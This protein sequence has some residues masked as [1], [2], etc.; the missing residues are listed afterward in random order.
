M[1][2]NKPLPENQSADAEAV[3]EPLQQA[4]VD[5]EIKDKNTEK[6]TFWAKYSRNIATFWDFQAG[7]R[8]DIHPKSKNYF[9][10][11]LEGLAPYF[12][13]TEAHVFISEDGNLTTTIHQENEF[14]IT[15]RIIIQPLKYEYATHEQHE[16]APPRPTQ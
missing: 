12:F 14:L 4:S 1:N 6:S 2:T 11:G 13:E 8:H 9:L 10:I 5:E 3:T 15:Q 16:Y 7:F